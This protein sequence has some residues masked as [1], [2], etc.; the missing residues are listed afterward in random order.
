MTA[1]PI[2][3]IGVDHGEQRVLALVDGVVRID[4]NLAETIGIQVD[5]IR[6][7]RE[8]SDAGDAGDDGSRQA[9]S[10]HHNTPNLTTGL[11]ALPPTSLRKHTEPHLGRVRLGNSA[12]MLRQRKGACNPRRFH[13]ISGCEFNYLG[14]KYQSLSTCTQISLWVLVVSIGFAS[15]ARSRHGQRIAHIDIDLAAIGITLLAIEFR[16]RPFDGPH[17]SSKLA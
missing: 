2:D 12:A 3:R 16:G 8:A 15:R 9:V 7:A 10:L 17:Y 14:R 4:E 11:F 1:L 6:Q 5:G 13:P